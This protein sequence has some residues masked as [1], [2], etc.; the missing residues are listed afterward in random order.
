MEKLL[1]KV[2]DKSTGRP[3]PQEPLFIKVLLTLH[4]QALAVNALYDVT[5]A[6]HS[7]REL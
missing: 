7:L 4:L 6:V 5:I 2:F 3:L 1:H